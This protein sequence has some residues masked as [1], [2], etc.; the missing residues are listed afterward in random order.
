[1]FLWGL[2]RVC[3]PWE[4]LFVCLNFVVFGGVLGKGPG[5]ELHHHQVQGDGDHGRWIEARLRVRL[6]DPRPDSGRLRGLQPKV[7][8]RNQPSVWVSLITVSPWLCRAYQKQGRASIPL[9]RAL[10]FIG[11]IPW[12]WKH[13][14]HHDSAL[15]VSVLCF[16]VMGQEIFRLQKFV[17]F[18]A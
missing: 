15:D 8:V 1:M 17:A 18:H 5:D 6:P 10:P 13:R 3:L 14:A 9:Q 4:P 2:L 16:L 7:R 11:F 12:L